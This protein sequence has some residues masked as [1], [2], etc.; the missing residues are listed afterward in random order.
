MESVSTPEADPVTDDSSLSQ[1]FSSR[2][3]TIPDLSR[4]GETSEPE[5][6]FET[7]ERLLLAEDR[8]PQS[9]AIYSENEDDQMATGLSLDSLWQHQEVSISQI[10]FEN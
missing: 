4:L 7:N 10:Y 2:L 3:K 6:S 8:R 5:D 1:G 9:D